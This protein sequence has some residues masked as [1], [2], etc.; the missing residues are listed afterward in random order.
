MGVVYKA[1]HEKLKLESWP[2]RWSCWGYPDSRGTAF[3]P[4][5]KHVARLHHPHIIQ[6]YEIG[7]QKGRPYLALE[8]VSGGTLKDKLQGRPQ[9]PVATAE[10]VE[11]LAR[12]VHA[13]HLRGIV[14]RDLKPANILLAPAGSGDE[15]E[16]GYQEAARE[17]GSP[18]ITDFGLAKQL[19]DDVGRTRFGEP[20]WATPAYM[21]PA[22]GRGRRPREVGAAT[23]V[24]ALGAILYEM[25]TGRPPFQGDSA[26]AILCQVT[27]PLRLLRRRRSQHHLPRPL[28]AIC[29]KCLEKSPSRAATAVPRP[30]AD[31]L[32]RFLNHEPVQAQPGRADGRQLPGAWSVRNP[33]AACLLIALDGGPDVRGR[34][35]AF[36]APKGSVVQQTA[37]ASRGSSRPP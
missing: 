25:L 13:A 21:A 23:D 20:P 4:K 6:V 34:R 16:H 36:R 1:R 3:K 8:F 19:D 37:T 11:Q 5:R 12:A 35:S 24:Y 9:Q 10:L 29:L 30:L 17:Y 15:I 32:R 7:E 27:A 22:T 18:K 33:L 28:E 2:S 14:H 31:D 26:V